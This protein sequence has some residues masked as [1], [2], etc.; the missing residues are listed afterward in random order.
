MFYN[1]NILY[2]II[3][4]VRKWLVRSWNTVIVEESAVGGKN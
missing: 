1:N 2:Y 3:Y 4:S